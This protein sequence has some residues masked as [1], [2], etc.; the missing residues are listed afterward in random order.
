MSYRTQTA[1]EAQQIVYVEFSFQ[2]FNTGTI[3]IHMAN[4]GTNILIR[5][6]KCDFE[7]MFGD[8]DGQEWYSRTTN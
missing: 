5:D 4:C 7:S 2:T 3:S 8:P 1:V 6:L